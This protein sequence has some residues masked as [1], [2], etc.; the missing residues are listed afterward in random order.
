MCCMGI[1]LRDRFLPLDLAFDFDLDFAL[2]LDLDLSIALDLDLDFPED[3]YWK[4]PVRHTE[5]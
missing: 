4:H 3:T 1:R 2:D 5:Q